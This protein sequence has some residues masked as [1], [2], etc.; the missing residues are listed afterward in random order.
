MTGKDEAMGS[1]INWEALTPSELIRMAVEDM[2]KVMETDGVEL[3]MTCWMYIHEDTDVCDVCA[4]GAV[5]WG[6]FGDY[7]VRDRLADLNQ[8][9]MHA[10]NMIG[11]MGSHDRVQRLLS[12]DSFRS[13]MWRDGMMQFY[14]DELP[15]E[16]T[17]P[18]GL[19][20]ITMTDLNKY[21]NPYEVMC[22]RLIRAAGIL[23]GAGM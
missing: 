17:L 13:G 21:P 23:E 8:R 15:E 11:M 4:A 20:S 18:A 19:R 3:N 1:A 9:S 14:N 22:E 2:R 6:R 7:A 10:E 16:F 12:L 5:L